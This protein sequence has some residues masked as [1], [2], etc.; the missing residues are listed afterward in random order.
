MPTTCGKKK[1][2]GWVNVPADCVKA[3]DD[4]PFAPC[5]AGRQKIEPTA[6]ELRGTG[7]SAVGE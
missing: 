2:K 5:K 3:P 6:E 4:H 7:D 1:V